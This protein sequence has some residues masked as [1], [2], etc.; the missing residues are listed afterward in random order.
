M[1]NKNNINEEE[2]ISDR[3]ELP[4]LLLNTNMYRVTYIGVIL[5]SEEARNIVLSILEKQN[6]EKI[7][8]L[9]GNF[10]LLINE[11]GKERY[12]AYRNAF[13]TSQLF[14]KIKNGKFIF[15]HKLNSIVDRF[16]CLCEEYFK[17]Y[18]NTEIDL[19]Q[20]T[21]YRGISRL[22][23]GYLLKFEFNQV[24]LK[25]IWNIGNKYKE[26]SK[27]EYIYNFNY[28]LKNVIGE[29]IDYFE[30]EKIG[31]E[32]S[33][34]MDSSTI[35][36][37][38]RV[39]SPNG[40]FDSISSIINPSIDSQTEEGN[41]QLIQYINDKLNFV[42]LQSNT[43]D[44]WA[45]KNAE[46]MKS[47]SD[48][49][50]PLLINYDMYNTIHNEIS[51][52]GISAVF[53]GDG[54]DEVFCSTRSYIYDYFSN[55]RF[56]EGITLLEKDALFLNQPIW[57]LII[58]HAFPH[59]LPSYV[60]FD[61][62]K[63]MNR[64]TWYNVGNSLSVICS[65][66]WIKKPMSNMKY[67]EIEK[68]RN[69][70]LEP[71]IEDKGKH[72]DYEFMTLVSNLNWLDNT[73]SYPNGINRIYPFKDSRIIELVFNMPFDIKRELGLNKKLLRE[74]FTDIIPQKILKNPD[75]SGFEFIIRK[76]FSNEWNFI[77]KLIDNSIAAEYGWIDKEKLK[78]AALLYKYG[79]KEFIN[80][81]VRTLSLEL[82][83]QST[84]NKNF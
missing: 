82:W 16:S 55:K 74:S 81:L 76:G 39:I 26:L 21:P 51:S 27:E 41:L 15:S 80:P 1:K 17:L 37:I 69:K 13:S 78:N 54:A 31:I 77:N 64:S 28:I 48:E 3:M 25:K 22:L 47:S 58:A 63:R 75:R 29:Y 42:P 11:K 40:I 57:K 66:D 79:Q 34:G 35:A 45:F 44:F 19:T 60:K 73:I 70:I 46:N 5:N 72:Y 10:T 62:L 67:S 23:P 68:H 61:F 32:I 30:N 38:I 8:E 33:G 36:S 84:V 50:N 20:L 65:P 18:L 59:M 53:S 9:K 71:Y 4:I 83:L 6:F 56:K 14:Y 52:K 49:P 7:N 43:D 24:K 12:Y 2:N